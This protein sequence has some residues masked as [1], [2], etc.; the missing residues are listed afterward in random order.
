[1]LEVRVL[2]RAYLKD[3]EKKKFFSP[4][5]LVSVSPVQPCDC[6]SEAIIPEK[7]RELRNEGSKAN[8]FPAPSTLIKTSR[9]ARS[10]ARQLRRGD[11]AASH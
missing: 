4:F 1:M 10:D 7:L 6:S 3:G 11:L 2:S 5:S 8:D 9:R